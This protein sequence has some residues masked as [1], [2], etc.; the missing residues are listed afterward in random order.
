MKKNITKFSLAIL[1]V[2]FLTAC[3]KYTKEETTS[4][5]VI[6][7]SRDLKVITTAINPNLETMSVLYGNEKAYRAALDGNRQHV[8]G[9]KYVYLTW[10]Y[11]ENPKWFG[12]NISKN[13]L[14]I[15]SI[16]VK[17]DEQTDDL[18]YDYKIEKGN[19]LPVNGIQLKQGD[20]IA[21]LF[22]YKPSVLP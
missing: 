5:R 9:E 18:I 15:E 7:D 8:S 3:S 11:I 21:Y 20:R 10:K 12:S 1:S 13:L 14:A 17:Q 2:L 4:N 16:N 19:P 22:D 6:F